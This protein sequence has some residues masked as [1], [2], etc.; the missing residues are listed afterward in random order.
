MDWFHNQEP[1]NDGCMKYNILHDFADRVDIEKDTT[2]N[3]SDEIKEEMDITKTIQYCENNPYPREDV[4][5]IIYDRIDFGLDQHITH[6]EKYGVFIDDGYYNFDPNHVDD[7]ERN[8][9]KITELVQV[10]KNKQDGNDGGWNGRDQTNHL[11]RIIEDVFSK[12]IPLY[13]YKSYQNNTE[14]KNP[15]HSNEN[16]KE[17]KT[18]RIDKYPEHN[19]ICILFDIGNYFKDI[20]LFN[21]EN[22]KNL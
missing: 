18:I 7:K 20:H 22:I 16:I 21:W 11:G 8:I 5:I 12:M 17:I 2:N 15:N 19:K 1:K 14:I 4:I 13:I 3:I 6:K 9:T 10:Y